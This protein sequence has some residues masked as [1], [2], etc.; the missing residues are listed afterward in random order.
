MH[1]KEDQPEGTKSNPQEDSGPA[2]PNPPVAARQRL[3]R[4]H[5]PSCPPDAAA[6]RTGTIDG[7]AD[8]AVVAQVGLAPPPTAV[9][10]KS[11][12]LTATTASEMTISPI[13]MTSVNS[14]SATA[15]TPLCLLIKG[16]SDTRL[17]LMLG[18]ET[19]GRVLWDHAAT[20]ERCRNRFVGLST[21]RK[22][23]E[24]TSAPVYFLEAAPDLT[25]WKIEGDDRIFDSNGYVQGIALGL[26][27]RADSFSLIPMQRRQQRCTVESPTEA[28]Q[29]LR[30]RLSGKGNDLRLEGDLPAKVGELILDG[31]RFQLANQAPRI[32]S[33]RPR[34]D[35][36]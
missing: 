13:P 17:Q 23:P 30:L 34:K 29:V 27:S 16:V 14:I 32:Y 8:R 35:Q 21:M 20:C 5:Y 12:W 33:C 6:A 2:E 3:D 36:A 24:S 4:K 7:E 1:N 28:T 11:P 15:V 19:P 22:I 31:A 26:E 9:S 10:R 25:D 18:R